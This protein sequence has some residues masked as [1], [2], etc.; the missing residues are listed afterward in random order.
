MSKPLDP[1]RP[2]HTVA[3]IAALGL[4][5][6][7]VTDEGESLASLKHRIIICDTSGSEENLRITGDYEVVEITRE[8]EDA[9]NKKHGHDDGF[10]GWPEV[11]DW[12]EENRATL[13]PDKVDAPSENQEVRVV[14]TV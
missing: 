4:C 3:Q 6:I 10:P 2:I 9:I 13:F 14:V 5:I 8:V 12:I 7:K 1:Q 11:F